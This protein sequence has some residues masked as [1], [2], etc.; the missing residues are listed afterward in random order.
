MIVSSMLHQL[1]PQQRRLNEFLHGS[2]A[3]DQVNV[4]I[5]RTLVNVSDCGK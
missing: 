5:I 1:N 2:C 3:G 4:C